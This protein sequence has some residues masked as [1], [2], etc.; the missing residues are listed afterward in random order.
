MKM[1]APKILFRVDSGVM[2]GAGHVMRCLTLAN[3]LRD[4]G[5][6]ALFVVRNHEGHLAEK[7]IAD[8]HQTAVLEL[9][10]IQSGAQSAY[11]SW[12]G[13]DSLSDA[14]ATNLFADEFGADAIVADH[15]AIDQTWETVVRKAG[16]FMAVLDD[17]ADRK[18]DCDLLVDQTR[19]R[20]AQDYQDLTPAGAII[21]TGTEF[22]LLRPEFAATRPSS[23]DRRSKTNAVEHILI[24]MG[25]AD[26]GNATGSILQ[27]LSGMKLPEDCVITAIVGWQS[28]WLKDNQAQAAAMPHDVRVISGAGNM[29][30]LLQHTDLAIGAAGASAWERCCLGVPTVMVQLADNQRLIA[31]GL[32]DTGAAISITVDDVALRLA[33]IVAKLMSDRDALALMSASAARICDGM[34]AARVAEIMLEAYHAR[35]N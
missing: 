34:G 30:E 31:Q 33:E 11:S 7:L 29:A 14:A 15:Y 1:Q 19:G 4:R 12:L 17:L 5:A 2:I 23:L 32:A 10:S 3:A 22:A 16:R 24:S 28:P 25:G 18:H 6:Q 35:A 20:L 26:Q 8:G 27:A 9:D 13:A 21:L